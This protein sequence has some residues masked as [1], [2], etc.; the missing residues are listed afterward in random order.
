[1]YLTSTVVH[2]GTSARARRRH[3]NV[4]HITTFL[5]LAYSLLCI[6]ATHAYSWFCYFCYCRSTND[7]VWRIHKRINDNSFNVVRAGAGTH[8][9]YTQNRIQMK[10]KE[11]NNK[12]RAQSEQMKFVFLFSFS[13]VYG[14][15]ALLACRRAICVRVCVWNICGSQAAV[16][17]QNVTVKLVW[18]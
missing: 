8:N 15:A 4:F 16:Y 13:R 3:K 9:I 18:V 5:A 6:S 14:V 2:I 10:T 17:D 7:S 1:M 12:T 11:K